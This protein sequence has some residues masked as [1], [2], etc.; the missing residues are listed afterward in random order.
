MQATRTALGAPRAHFRNIGSTNERARVLAGSGAP[1]GTL[2][3]AREQTAGRGRH[4][5]TWWAP[6]GSSLLMSLVLREAPPLLAL[7]A[8]L[9]V[10]DVAGEAARIKWPNDIVLERSEDAA[11]A[12]ALAKLAGILIEGS[13]PQTWVALGIGINVA[14]SPAAAPEELR[15]RIASLEQPPSAIEPLLARLLAA[16]TERIAEPPEATLAAW[17]ER[18]ALYGRLIGWSEGAQE[19]RAEGI[20][21]EG[22][23]L[24]RRADGTRATLG[25]GEVHLV[26]R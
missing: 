4:G 17:R 23:L 7:S 9:G 24:V 19:G 26:G 15:D 2:V 5:R 8:A 11:T 21:G 25:A 3:T 13:P 6:A 1:H 20:D 12:P 18:D 10:C 14:V 22:R 16:L